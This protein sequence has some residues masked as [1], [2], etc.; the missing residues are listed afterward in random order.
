MRLARQTCRRPNQINANLGPLVTAI[1]VNILQ[2][3]LRVPWPPTDGGSQAMLQL[4]QALQRSGCRVELA[5]LNTPKHHAAPEVIESLAP[6]WATDIDTR[7]RPAAALRN[8]LASKLPYNVERFWSAAHAARLEERI[9]AARPDLV[10]M[11]GVYLAL[12]IDAV[13][14]AAPRLPVVLRAH[15]VEYQ[16]W[17]RY[18]AAERPG[19]RR[20]YFQ[21]LARRGQAFERDRLPRFDGIAALT[22]EDAAHFRR[23]GY[24]GP[25]AVLPPGVDPPEKAAPP[26]LETNGLCFLGSLEWLPNLQGLDWFLDE[27]WPR[28]RRLRPDA[29]FH[30]AGRNPP[31]ELY[32]RAGDGVTVH[33][34][35]PDAL[36]FLGRY[37]AVVVPLL[38]GSGIRMKILEAMAWGKAV[39]TTPVGAEGIDAPEGETL[40]RAA[41]PDAFAKSCADLL[42]DPEGAARTGAAA[43]AWVIDH[44]GW[45]ALAPRYLDFFRSLGA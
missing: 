42:S 33:G 15:N 19:P 1:F 43:R 28:L 20:W 6:A 27:V 39:V 12:Y 45:A 30:I 31:A 18:A 38:S 29:Q 17:E 9:A 44:F 25:V 24:G 2:L 34:P 26:P 36:E 22:A 37:G 5:A 21:H 10:L 23:L 11:E 13:R 7:L 35:V 3:T 32:A 8:L 40:R 16:I 14:R 4:R 41:D